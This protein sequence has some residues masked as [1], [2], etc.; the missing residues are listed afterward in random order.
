[1][2]LFLGI[3]CTIFFILG[4]VG[5]F[6]GPDRKSAISVTIV[7]FI[8]MI[9]MYSLGGNGNSQ[10]NAEENKVKQEEPVDK[11]ATEA[12]QEANKH[13]NNALTFV[14]EDESQK[15]LDEIVKAKTAA[16]NYSR[17]QKVINEIS[18]QL[19]SVITENIKEALEAYDVDTARDNIGLVDSL[20]LKT[21]NLETLKGKLSKAKEVIAEIG[22]KPKN[23]AWDSA[24]RPV[25]EFLDST[26]KDPGSVEYIE[27][28]AVHLI[29]NEE[30]KYWVVRVAYRAKNSFGGYVV[31]EKLASIQNGIV[32]GMDDY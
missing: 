30:G 14:E 6:T 12:E 2:W 20:D 8:L 21:P 4:V 31:K 16:P 28:S 23:S 18:T 13:L 19:Q 26:L 1:M 10:E 29:D 25:T 15:A 27:W 32:V 3:V 7:F 5:I 22:A 17:I 11:E 9:V 24:V